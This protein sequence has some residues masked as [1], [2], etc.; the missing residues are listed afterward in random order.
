ML[1]LLL[2]QK[3]FVD[4]K[5]EYL[6]HG[7]SVKDRMALKMIVDA[8]KQG[9]LTPHKSVIVLPTS[10]NTGIGVALVSLVKGKCYKFFCV[11]YCLTK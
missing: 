8:E 1:L 6:N 5:C 2:R 3:I 10:G 11:F 9:I 7:G 4:V